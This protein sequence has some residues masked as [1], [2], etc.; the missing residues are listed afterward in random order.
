MI[1]STAAVLKKGTPTSIMTQD[2]VSIVG[3]AISADFHAARNYETFS[4]VQFEDC[5][6]G[7]IRLAGIVFE[8]CNF[9]NCHFLCDI[10]D[11]SFI[12]CKLVECGF[13]RMI[14]TSVTLVASEIVASEFR[15]S[16]L[17]TVTGGVIADSSFNFCKLMGF[18]ADLE[19]CSFAHVSINEEEE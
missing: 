17:N 19:N 7:K 15:Y 1:L 5:T 2:A 18:G 13:W 3:V 16:F 6:F 9:Y 8:N 4:D 11:C 10:Y 12:N 14:A